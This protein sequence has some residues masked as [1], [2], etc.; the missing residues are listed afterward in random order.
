MH[1]CPSMCKQCHPAKTNYGK[2]VQ[3]PAHPSFQTSLGGWKP[4]L[5]SQHRLAYN[6]SA[7]LKRCKCIP[8]MAISI[9]HNVPQLTVKLR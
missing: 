8:G 3:E 5:A 7:E 4:P 9:S 6:C 1:W 2:K